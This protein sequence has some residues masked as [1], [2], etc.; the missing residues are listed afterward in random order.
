[1]H[2]TDLKEGGNNTGAA[3][4]SGNK[5]RAAYMGSETEW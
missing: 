2:T 4:G 5:Q 3:K 1:M